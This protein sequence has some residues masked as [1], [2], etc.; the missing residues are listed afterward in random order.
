[1]RWI[2]C[3]DREKKDLSI[4]IKAKMLAKLDRC[5]EELMEY[6]TIVLKTDRNNIMNDF[7][8]S[9]NISF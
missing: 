7:L 4:D 6:W 1:M 9:Q 3:G 5:R 8:L 2:E